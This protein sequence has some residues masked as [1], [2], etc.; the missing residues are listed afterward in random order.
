MGLWRGSMSAHRG[1][2]PMSGANHS[3]KRKI[4]IGLA[5]AAAGAI[6]FGAVADGFA[7][8]GGFGGGGGFR[9]GGGGG[10]GGFA[11]GGRGGGG[12][13]D[14]PRNPGGGFPGGGYPGGP[15]FP[16]GGGGVIMVPP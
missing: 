16:G 11:A 12:G 14:G 13:G 8:R 3:P 6:T 15:R 9:G 1:G 2:V 5:L 7:Q 10:G 4:R